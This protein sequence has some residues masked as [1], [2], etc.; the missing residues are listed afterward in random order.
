MFLQMSWNIGLNTV[1]FPT[2]HNGSLAVARSYPPC[3][4]VG[5][6]PLQPKH[7]QILIVM[8][9]A[10]FDAWSTRRF[11][12]NGTG[13][14]LNPILRPFAGNASLYAAMQVGPTILDVVSRRM[15]TSRHEWMRH[16]WWLPQAVSAAL[17][18]GCGIHNLGL[19]A[20]SRPAK[21]IIA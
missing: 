9:C 13:Q 15:M 7:L 17:S 18:V 5:R 1:Q 16:T 20:S 21:S 8:S 11:V 10:A 3:P 19:A 14:Q 4:V 6:E 12:S 2:G